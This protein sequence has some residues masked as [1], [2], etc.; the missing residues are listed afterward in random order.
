MEPTRD[1]MEEIVTLERQIAALEELT[2]H[3]FEIAA[4]RKAISTLRKLLVLELA[5]AA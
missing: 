1:I 4:C 5:R 3:E 2:G